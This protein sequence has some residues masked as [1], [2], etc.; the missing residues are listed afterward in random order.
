MSTGCP[1]FNWGACY[2]QGKC[3]LKTPKVWAYILISLK[4]CIAEK[5][6]SIMYCIVGIQDNL[7]IQLWQSYPRSLSFVSLK[8]PKQKE[9][10]LLSKIIVEL[11]DFI[12][13][14]SFSHPKMLLWK[15]WYEYF[16]QEYC[17]EFIAIS[18]ALSNPGGNQ[19]T[20][21]TVLKMSKVSKFQ[22][23]IP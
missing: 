21:V 3:I 17:F 18:S 2:I 22:P 16:Y 7:S 9:E 15:T 11:Q 20:W 6:L 8:Y 19:V 10:I 12:C 23:F 14:D 5:V 1:V 4:I 13:A